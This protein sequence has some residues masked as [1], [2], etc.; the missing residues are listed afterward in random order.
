M[1][2][3]LLKHPYLGDAKTYTINHQ[4]VIEIKA[5]PAV[6]QK[7][8]ESYESYRAYSWKYCLFP[9]SV[10]DNEDHQFGGKPGAK[11]PSIKKVVLPLT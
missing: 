7:W 3:G 11:G 9:D 8:I 6:Y 4:K 5:E 1:H 10:I 2:T